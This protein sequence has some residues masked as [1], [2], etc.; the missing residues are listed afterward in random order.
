MSYVYIVSAPQ[1]NGFVSRLSADLTRE[2]IPHWYD[3]GQAADETV[4]KQL[5]Q[6]THI[7]AVLSPAVM[8]NERVLA[9]LE[10]ARQHKLERLAVRLTAVDSLPPQL[11][12][13]L[14]LDFSDEAQYDVMLDTL[15]E[16]LSLEPTPQ[17]PED[18]MTGLYSENTQIRQNAIEA[19]AAFYRVTDDFLKEKAK[20]ELR[21]LVFREREA[22]LKALI[23]T[24]LQSFDMAVRPP[25]E[26]VLPTK[27]ELAKQAEGRAVI[28]GAVQPMYFWR[29]R[30]WHV[31]W[32]V[33]GLVVGVI[34]G[35]AGGHWAY[36]L[37]VIAVTL[38]MPQL[39][40]LIRHGGEFEWQPSGSVMGNLVL[41]ALLAGIVG[42]V[43]LALMDGVTASGSLVGVLVAV[44]VGALI[45]WLASV[46]LPA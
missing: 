2:K 23:H 42:A 13:V 16:D 7:I 31:I 14:P 43:L 44:V 12:G 36:A 45:G 46:K 3:D 9:A 15:L 17:L 6:A 24:T 39:N 40:I 21:M 26:V 37:P 5:Q 4:Y 22:R 28:V 30:R 18:I 32:G 38:I 25:E 27:E 20:E 19:L 41:S 11:Q 33:L 1:D 10:Y 34:L 35:I 29:S 8:L